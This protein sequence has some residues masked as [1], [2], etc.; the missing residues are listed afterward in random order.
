MFVEAYN[1]K[2]KVLCDKIIPQLDGHNVHTP[3]ELTEKIVNTIKV[4]R[5]SKIAVLFNVEFVFTLIALK[6]ANPKNITFFGDCLKKQ[7]LIE[8]WGCVW[9][10]SN[11]LLNLDKKK[12][13]KY[14]MKFDVIVGN[15]PYQDKKGNENS[16]NSTDLYAVFVEKSFD[17]IKD[18]GQ[19]A[20]IIPSAWSGPKNNNLKT[21]LF[22]T[23]Q[24]SIFDTHGKKWFD[25]TMNTC[26]FITR[27]FRKGTTVITDAHKNKVQVELNKNSIVGLNLNDLPVMEKMKSFSK[28]ANLGEIWLR[29]NIHL[30]QV[31]DVKTKNGV[32][33]ILSVGS[34]GTELENTVIIDSNAE[35][36]GYNKFK[37][38]IPN[39]GSGDSIGNI[40]IAT[41]KQV[42][43]H[44]VVFLV[45]ETED[46]LENLKNYLES[47]LIR[48]LI[49]AVKISTPNSKTVFGN[50]PMIDF[51]K[52]W[53][54]EELYAYFEITQDE[55]DYIEANVK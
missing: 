20:L 32:E 25:V 54:D 16:T 28:K 44:S 30:N 29:G 39:L 33:L 43:G 35:T 53:T 11:I 41:K 48:F 45:T 23:H 40:K 9:V 26:Y 36:T 52:S 34:F 12:R 24:P 49:N 8:S 38:V 21:L 51:T 15:P 19:I 47:K 13:E 27:K 2:K 42:G 6:G 22:E 14:K 1:D 50:I 55:I 10:N 37:L 3:F 46:E 4:D 31:D 18:D 17:L 5:K 7:K